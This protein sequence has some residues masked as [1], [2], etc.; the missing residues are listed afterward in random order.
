MANEPPSSPQSARMAIDARKAELE[1]EIIALNAL[2]NATL[3]VN[4]LPNEIFVEIIL[5]ADYEDYSVGLNYDKEPREIGTTHWIPLM[6]VCQRWRT[7]ICSTPKFWRSIDVYN[8]VDWLKLCL[9]RVGNSTLEVSFHRDRG[10]LLGLPVLTPVAERISTILFPL[11]DPWSFSR[12]PSFIDRAFPMVVEMGVARYTGGPDEWG[13]W[14]T[15][16]LEVEDVRFDLTTAR[17]PSLRILHLQ[18]VSMPWTPS[19]V[20]RLTYL[21]VTRCSLDA[22]PRLDV[23]AFLDVLTTCHELTVLRLQKYVSSIVEYRSQIP[24]RVIT[25]LKLRQFVLSDDPGYIVKLLSCIHLPIG[26]HVII[27]PIV[28]YVLVDEPVSFTA[29]FPPDRRTVPLLASAT[30]ARIDIFEGN[31]GFNINVNDPKSRGFHVDFEF[32]ELCA[33]SPLTWLHI[34]G[35]LN[36]VSLNGWHRLFSAFPQLKEVDIDCTG[37]S[38]AGIFLALAFPPLTTTEDVSVVC[39]K[40]RFLTIDGDAYY[41]HGDLR[42]VENVLRTR[43]SRG[44]QDLGMLRLRLLHDTE[45]HFQLRLTRAN[46]A[47]AELMPNGKLYFE[48][49]VR[50]QSDWESEVESE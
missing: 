40:L 42:M 19:V 31:M 9:T 17:F 48:Q 34:R 16:E 35:D 7:V 50:P 14:P 44:A 27:S 46:G 10:A 22:G 49:A 4:Q 20:S 39:P 33:G 38:I 21:E 18:G 47:L 26:V 8:T 15:R 25:I 5:L 45:E 28:E 3:S 24:K 2:R 13:E 6:H 30:A 11:I 32:V 12:I 23:S 43:A 1:S 37:P 36:H 29:L 41:G